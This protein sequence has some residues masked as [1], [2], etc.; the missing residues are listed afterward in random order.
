M[1]D[2]HCHLNFHSFEKDFDIVI[3]RAF[4]AG[5]KR[6]INVGTSIESSQKAVELSQKYENLYAIVGI[7]PHHA[8]KLSDNW[9]VELRKIAQNKKVVAIGEIGLDYFSYKSNG[10][11]DSNLQKNVF[12]TQIQLAHDL[13]IPLQIHNRQAGEDILE[14]LNLH[15]NLLKSIPGMF[16]CFAGSNETLKKALN[17]GF[18]IGFDGN[19]TY[20][21]IAKG[22]TVKLSELCKISPIDRI[23]TETDA[24]FLTP[25]PHRGSRNEP[26]Y[27]IIVGE[28]IAKIKAISFE[29]LKKITI[30]NAETLF[31]L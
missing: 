29:K 13:K 25:E 6:I 30:Q 1:I 12:E 18:Y 27:V 22:E 4:N 19:I 11:V 10:I 7:H 9:E 24:P 5:V 8:D 28:E 20:K 17:L 14:I 3:K 31:N 23:V 16:H 26:S 2:V 21:G 15:K